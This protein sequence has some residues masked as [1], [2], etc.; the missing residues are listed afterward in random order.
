MKHKP[1]TG[2]VLLGLTLAALF[3]STVLAQ[4]PSGFREAKEGNWY[5]P[6]E[7]EMWAY[8]GGDRD[9][10]DATLTRISESQGERRNMEQPD[11]QVS[12]GP[13]NWIFEFSIAGEDALKRAESAKDDEGALSA[14]EEALSYFH[15]AAAP[16]TQSD[17]SISAFEKAA[18]AYEAAANLLPGSFIRAQIPFDGKSFDIFLQ[19]PP[20]EGPFPVLVM[21]NGSD[22]SSLTAFTYYSKHLLPKGIAFLSMD[23]P[24]M[25]RS[26]QYDVTDGITDKLMV[27]AVNWAKTRPELDGKNIF[28]QGISFGGNA[29]A[30]IFLTRPELDLAGVVYT[31]GPIQQAFK[32]PPPAY[33][34]L[35]EFTIDGVQV[36]LGLPTDAGLEETANR[37]RALALFDQGLMDG[38]MIST[39]ILALNNN[40]DPV[41][42]LADMDKMLEMASDAKRI[43]FDQPGHCPP[44]DVREPIVA[45]WIMEHLR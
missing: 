22:Q 8:I 14:Y 39:P 6:V 35:P 12:Y 3:P 11:T 31:C 33:G 24:G 23:V 10:I 18:E 17:E 32:L 19:T 13:G 15:T 26:R 28:V 27:E 7:P 16:I 2:R 45:A 36:R 5:H 34:H 41:A 43:V 40:N 30:R 1:Q 9:I 38:K 37:L 21:S 44:H 4:D 25:G 20:G 29:A 42:P